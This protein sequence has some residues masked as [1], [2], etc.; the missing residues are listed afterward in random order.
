MA[1]HSAGTYRIH[2]GRGGGRSGQQR[3]SPLDSWPDNGNLD[4]ARRLLWPIYQRYPISWAD[5]LILAGNVALERMGMPTFGFGGG[6]VDAMEPELV[7]WGYETQW[8]G[9]ER[10]QGN[11]QLNQPLGAVQMGLSM[12][13]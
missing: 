6:R 8:M 11:R 7:N 4:K 5:L 1:W 9:D 12:Y 3:F 10:Y 13:Q 2:D